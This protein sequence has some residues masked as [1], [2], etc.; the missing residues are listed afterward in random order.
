MSKPPTILKGKKM[1]LLNVPE[2]IQKIIIEK[3]SE[4]KI[5]CD[6]E[7]SQD[8]AIYKMLRT[9]QQIMCCDPALAYKGQIY[10][11]V[12]DINFENGEII[13]S[14]KVPISSPLGMALNYKRIE[15]SETPGKKEA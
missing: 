2:D 11:P 9:Y 13:L 7:R 14:L 4:E 6:C 12:Y 1:K 10:T 8:Y 15:P 5:N 3:Q